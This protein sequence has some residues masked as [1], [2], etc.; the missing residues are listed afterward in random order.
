MKENGFYDFCGWERWLAL[1]SFIAGK[2]ENEFIQ[3][4]AKQK[5]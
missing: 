5:L 1:R 4:G 3:N 2:W